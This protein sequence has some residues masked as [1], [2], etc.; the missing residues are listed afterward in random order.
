M[1]VLGK[2]ERI[3]NEKGWSTY[4]L[5]YES[6]LTQSTLFNMFKRKTMPSLV[7]LERICDAFGMTLSEFFSDEE[8]TYCV[9]EDEKTVI[10]V[11]RSLD[12]ENKQKVLIYCNEKSKGNQ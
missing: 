1:D 5:A 11:Y 7:T 3:K 4:Q 9:S 8:K 12:Y 6:G 10:N 2:I